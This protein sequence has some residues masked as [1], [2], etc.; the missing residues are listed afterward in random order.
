MQIEKMSTRLRRRNTWES[1]DLGFSLGQRWFLPLWLLW[2]LPASAVLTLAL[3]LFENNLLAWFVAWWLQPLYERPLLHF[4]SRA[5]FGEYP[6]LRHELRNYWRITLPQILPLIT[7]RR[8]NPARNFA[9]PVAMLE[10]LKGRERRRRLNV[11]GVGLN[12]AAVWFS[13]LCWC[14][15]LVL[16][17]VQIFL[18]QM[19]IPE[20]SALS[21]FTVLQD[22]DQ[23]LHWLGCVIWLLAASVT[24]PFFVAGGFTLYISRR[25]QLEG[26]DIE[27]EFRKLT[28]R[29]QNRQKTSALAVLLLAIPLLTMPPAPAQAADTQAIDKAQA[30]TLI[31]E[32]SSRP[33]FGEEKTRVV[34]RK[35]AKDTEPTKGNWLLQ[36]RKNLGEWFA[37][38]ADVLPI[39]ATFLKTLLILAA[40]GLIVWL[41]LRYTHWL[42]WLG[43]GGGRHKRKQR[44]PT[45]LFGLE[46]SKASLPD[47]IAGTA[48][49]LLEQ[50]R[51]R[52]ALSLLFRASLSQLIHH[53]DLPISDSATEGECLRLVERHRPAS[54]VDYFRRLT[55]VWLLLAYA[56]EPPSNTTTRTLCQQWSQ[57]YRHASHEGDDA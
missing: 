53:N 9:E 37:W 10:G 27:L 6:P 31:Q 21:I 20:E 30:K 43:T 51:V 42:D 8:F 7:L 5:L 26:W 45:S 11:L 17:G 39:L 14:F 22:P 24:A 36:L 28:N 1:I 46:L 52:A 35:I 47:D 40:A 49:A 32:I 57:H 44:K 54:E 16:I 4:L 38:L 25:T 56:H 12:G 55:R 13:L 19:V 34:W 15:D 41:L 23:S 18:L 3:A 2:M 33:E 48:L 50:G 29:L